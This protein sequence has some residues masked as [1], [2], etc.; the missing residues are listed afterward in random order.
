L[1]PRTR[2]ARGPSPGTGLAPFAPL[3][4]LR[5]SDHPKFAE[6]PNRQPGGAHWHRD[7]PDYDK[8]RA[9][10]AEFLAVMLWEEMVSLRDGSVPQGYG[11]SR[12]AQPAAPRSLGIT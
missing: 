7:R 6:D 1:P 5:N 9:D 8:I 3:I 11:I 12:E 10:L 4:P 2:H